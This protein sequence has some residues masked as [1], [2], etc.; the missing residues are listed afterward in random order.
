MTTKAATTTNYMECVNY[1]HSRRSRK[2]FLAKTSV[3]SPVWNCFSES[4]ARLEINIM[5][6]L[7]PPQQQLEQ[8]DPHGRRNRP[9]APQCSLRQHRSPERSHHSLRPLSNPL[10]WDEHTSTQKGRRLPL[11]THPI[12][13]ATTREAQSASGTISSYSWVAPAKKRPAQQLGH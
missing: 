2:V 12:E 5:T 1:I 13:T 4:S 6:A 11:Q 9:S 8:S 7:P 3:A 10:G